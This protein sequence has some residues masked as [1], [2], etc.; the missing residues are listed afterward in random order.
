MGVAVASAADRFQIAPRPQ[1][2]LHQHGVHIHRAEIIFQNADIVALFH[3][4]P[5][6]PAQKSGLA[7]PQKAGDQVY[8]YHS[9]KHLPC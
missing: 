3:Q 2:V 6:I 7:C 9:K 4:I 1:K 5:D 8:L